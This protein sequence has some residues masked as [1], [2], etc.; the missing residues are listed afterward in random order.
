MDGRMRQWGGDPRW[1]H[2]QFLPL[3]KLEAFSRS[4]LSVFLTFLHA[5]ISCE[6]S[7]F[8]QYTAQFGAE[9][10]QRA[11]DTMLDCAGLSVHATALNSD[12]NIEFVQSVR[13]FQ[14]PLHEH[15]VSFVKEVLF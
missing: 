8:L 13:S 11:R 6:K 12:V 15:P 5:R 2:N 7:F 1:R 3:R 9:L 14:W 4:R 10:Y